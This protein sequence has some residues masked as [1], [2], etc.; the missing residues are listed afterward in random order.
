MTSVELK[1]GGDAVL[2]LITAVLSVVVTGLLLEAV[3][4]RDWSVQGWEWPEVIAA[5]FVVTLGA[6]WLVLLR[7]SPESLG[8]GSAVKRVVKSELERRGY[9]VQR[10]PS[11]AFDPDFALQVDFDYVLHHHLASR[12]DSRPFCFLQVGAN[13][14]VMDDPLHRRVRDGGWRGILVEPQASHFERLK[15]NYAGLDGLSFVN[16]AISEQRGPRLM[17]VIEDETG[18]PIEVLGGLASFREEPLRVFHDKMVSHYPGSRVGSIEVECVTFADVLGDATYLDLLQIDVEGYDVALL[19]LF[20]F[21]RITPPIVRFEHRHVV[22]SELDEAFELL[23]GRGYRMVR[24]EY[25]TIGY[26]PAPRSTRRL[27]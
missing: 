22:A 8:R 13:D 6:F 2:A 16:A 11:P 5:A 20:D 21:G 15:E 9:R 10:I 4:D 7:R 19:K 3:T 25:D 24:E 12:A 27:R 26:A 18:A 17:F 1:R 23:A 14:G